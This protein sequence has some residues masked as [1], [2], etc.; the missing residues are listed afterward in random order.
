MVRDVSCDLVDVD[1]LATQASDAPSVQVWQQLLRGEDETPLPLAAHAEVDPTGTAMTTADFA[2][3]AMRACLTTDQLLR[4]HLRAQL[5]PYQVRGVAWLAST[6]ESEGGAVLADEMGLGKTVQAVG[7]L[8]LRVETGPQ[9]V[10]CPTSLVTNWAHEITRFAPGLT[11]YTGC[12]EEAPDTAGSVTIT[13]YARLRLGIDELAGRRWA[14]VIYDEAQALKNPRTQLSRAARRVDAQARIALTGTPIENSLDELWAILRVVAP[15]VFPH[16]AVFRRRFTRAVDDG[17]YGALQR[18]RVAVAPV[19]LA[20]TKARVASA[21]PPKIHNPVLVDLTAEQAEL[22]DAHLAAIEDAGFGVGIERHGRI[23]ATLTRLK[24]ICN[25]PALVTGDR[26]RGRLAGRSGKFDRCMEILEENMETGSPTLVFTQYRDT[27]D[28]LAD[29]LADRFDCDVPFFHGGL[30]P[31]RRDELVADFQ[32]G[33]TPEVM[34]MSLKAGGVGLT[35]TRA[36]DVIHFDRWWNPAVE[37]QASDR[38]HRIGQER[39]V[40]VTTLTTATTLEEH[41]DN[42]HRRKAALSAHPDES[43]ALAELTALSDERLI[44]VLRRNRSLDPAIREAE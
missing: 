38:V 24:Q 9:L 44:T 7:L 28:L 18:L 4:D 10:V 33:R 32:A 3:T 1:A 42:L 22:Y 14:T 17:D 36:C 20:R 19:M 13:S 26:D 43:S 23:L 8:S 39:P 2:R 37:A 34:V 16:R 21:L 5:R 25:H 29:H 40:T 41:I 12:I 27:G 35:L 11:V 31:G 6:A 30:T 15:S